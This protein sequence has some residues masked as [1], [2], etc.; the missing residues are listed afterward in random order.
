MKFY[1]K[2]ET[3]NKLKLKN[4]IIP[5]LNII[6]FK[7][8]QINEK[9]ILN[10]IKSNFFGKK[11][12]LRS[13]FD[14]EDT[15]NNSQAGKF[16]SFLNVKF[17]D[18]KKI[19]KFIKEIKNSKK[20]ITKNEVFFI[21]E[22]VENVKISGVILTKSLVNYSKCLTINYTIGKDT[23]LVTSGVGENRSLVYFTNK[24]YKIPTKFCNLEKLII[25]LQGIFKF[26]N[27]D[28]EFAIDNKKK[29]Y[30]LQVRPIVTPKKSLV[31]FSKNNK[32]IKKNIFYNLEKKIKKLKKKHY[33]LLGDTTYFGNMPDWNPAE[34]IGTKPKPLA[35]SLYQELITDHV[36]S[37]NRKKYG[38]RDLEQFHLMTTFCGSPYIDIRID[39]NSWLPEKLE[40]NISLKLCKYYLNEFAKNKNLQDKIE[41][42]LLFTCAT[43]A[44]KKS[45]FKK[46]K[47]TFSKKNINKIYKSLT[48]INSNLI[49]NFNED[50]KK[51]DELT[52]RQNSVNKSNLYYLDKIYF[53]V[54]D[55]KK[56]GTLPFAGLARCGFVAIEIL[57]SLVEENFITNEEKNKFLHNTNTI[58]NQIK[59]DLK[60][61]TKFN[62]LKK[63]G[64]LRPNTYEITSKNYRENFNVY[65]KHL[66]KNEINVN[67]NKKSRL[68]YLKKPNVKEIGFNCNLKKFEQFIRNAIIYREYSKFLF[69]KNIDL[70]FENLIAFGKKYKISRNDLSYIKISKILDMHFNI[71]NFDMI[72]NLKL[73]INE[74]KN[75]YENNKNI[76]L[77]DVINDERDIYV[78]TQKESKIN[79]IS[80]KKVSGKIIPLDE[81]KIKSDYKGI[82]CI[83]NADPGYDFLFSKN[84]KGLI[85][86]YGGLN[87]HMS[88]RCAE[89]N[90][91]AL[92]GVGE[93]NYEKILK[94]KNI[95]IDCVT[96]Q[97]SYF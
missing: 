64:H 51:L 9:K 53:L 91:P 7:D 74:N 16:K 93:S 58:M 6:K 8:F 12:A 46:L 79:F 24:K 22:M 10:K 31:V 52:L 73:H 49:V 42:D 76:S 84:I 35:L 29:I 34:M 33:S 97:I 43:F 39:F 21:Q 4:A 18:E 78:Q 55:C 72:A 77:P 50:I 37:T 90:L 1:S 63:Y 83:E 45:M 30:L 32:I 27:L 19:I 20:K 82:V 75:E 15:Q 81:N 66:N 59:Q 65:F 40:E 61:D 44:N 48:E 11:I 56:F 87:S 14:A 47:N 86:K 60:N 68:K 26:E 95:S 85:T 23:S 25:E 38:Y 17:N 92:I 80:D 57:N 2:A 3:L 54:E 96:N 71:G 89:L 41:F 94:H 69:S 62:F 5:K 28:I 67:N 70:I 36:W 13:S 88:I